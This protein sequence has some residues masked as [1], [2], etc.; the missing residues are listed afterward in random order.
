MYVRPLR[1]ALVAVLLCGALIVSPLT[2]TSSP[3][4]AATTTKPPTKF[5]VSYG[6]RLSRMSQAD[7][8]AALDDAVQLGV[9]WIRMDLSWTTVQP[10]GPSTYRWAGFDRVI[11]GARSRGLHVLPILTWTPAWARDAGCVRF[12]CPP[13]RRGQFAA[14]A[15][16]AVKRY[17]PLGVRTWE[18]WNEPNLNFFWPS[19]NPRRYAYL[20]KATFRAIR[21]VDPRATVLLGG[22]AALENRPPSIGP[23]QFLANVCKAGG[24]ATMSGVS[25]HPYTFPY[26]ASRRSS[27][28]AWSKINQTRWSLRYVLDRFKFRH[29]RIFVTEYGAPT[30]GVG[31]AGDGALGALLG[32]AT[33]VTQAWQAVMAADVVAQAD[34]N[35]DVNALFWYTNQDLPILDLRESSFGLRNLDGT[36]K[37][38]WL[39]FKTAVATASLD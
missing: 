28:S 27:G 1:A 8:D 20:L 33:Y 38:A 11:R 13:H 3:A 21:S 30:R 37:P 4:A 12:T 10:D 2:A 6:E 15:K 36:P 39:A 25:Y 19:P 22:L 32:T 17:R 23:R 29:K 31:V 14:F 18:V 26:L 16:A 7:L 24:C 34:R 9:G 5:G 35:P